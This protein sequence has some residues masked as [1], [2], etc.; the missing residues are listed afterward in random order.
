MLY[1]Y[2]S[3]Y[4][5]SQVGEGH[6]STSEEGSQ[7]ERRKKRRRKRPRRKKKRHLHGGKEVGQRV[8]GDDVKV[9]GQGGGGSSKS[10]SR[11]LTAGG[12]DEELDPSS[13]SSP[14]LRLLSSSPSTTTATTTIHSLT[15]PLLMHIA[16]CL[17]TGPRQTDLME[18]AWFLRDI[19]SMVQ[20]CHRWKKVV[21]SSDDLWRSVCE[22]RWVSVKMKG[23]WFVE[24]VMSHDPRLPR[25]TSSSSSSSST[26]LPQPSKWLDFVLRRGRCLSQSG[27]G[28]MTKDLLWPFDYTRMVEVY[29][30]SSASSSEGQQQQ[31]QR[32]VSA[33][34]GLEV[35]EGG[36]YNDGTRRWIA[37]AGGR[38]G[39]ER[40]RTFSQWWCI[41]PTGATANEVLDRW[42]TPNTP[43]T[44]AVE[45]MLLD[46]RTNK[47]AMWYTAKTQF[48]QD[49]QEV[50]PTTRAIRGLA[51]NK[52]IATT[53]GMA[54][55]HGE[56]S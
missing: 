19:T 10:S 21:R 41:P 55:S 53:T 13:S 2:C 1:L 37:G 39:E 56:Y 14:S 7:G 42:T 34:V 28:R 49:P 3:Y 22:W 30:A 17:G 44:V 33:A 6:G 50:L 54:F 46:K 4:Y 27:W 8:E 47:T 9:G 31:Q 25:A 29:V 15:D 45:V 12:V 18:P 24:D 32:V 26:S 23:Q 35:I 40:S 52:T 16:E 48:V 51:G 43:G 36:I 5:C 20:V 11:R 38:A